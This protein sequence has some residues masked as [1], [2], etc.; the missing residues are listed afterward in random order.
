V[1][2]FCLASFNFSLKKTTGL[3]SRLSTPPI[4]TPEASHS[5]V[6]SFSKSGIVRIGFC[7]PSFEL[8]KTHSSCL[9]PSK[10]L[11][12]CAI[13]QG[14]T[15]PTEIPN[16]P[17]IKVYQ[18]VKSLH[19]YDTSRISFIFFGSMFNPPVEITLPKNTNLSL[20]NSLF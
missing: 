1:V 7:N 17:L 16:E 19:L 12:S 3:P 9:C 20:Q 11:P 13:S 2:Y 4:T 6:K 10:D 15:Q 5:T 14:G 18:S 8:F